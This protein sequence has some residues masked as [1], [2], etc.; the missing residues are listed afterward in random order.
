MK[1]RLIVGSNE[2]FVAFAR[3]E[4][5]LLFSFMS[6][7]AITKILRVE[8]SID[9]QSSVVLVLL[10]FQVRRKVLLL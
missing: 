5:A 4:T 6:A 1:L 9:L 7:I 10:H 8:K 2:Q 3:G